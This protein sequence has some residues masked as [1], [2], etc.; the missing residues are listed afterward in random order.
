[1][2]DIAFIYTSNKELIDSIF[3]TLFSVYLF[4]MLGIAGREQN[5]NGQRGNKQPTPCQPTAHSTTRT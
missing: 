3:A 1:M 5:K 4:T 2:P